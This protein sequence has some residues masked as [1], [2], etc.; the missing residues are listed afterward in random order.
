[1]PIGS[2]DY[3]STT[4][5][6]DPLNPWP[7]YAQICIN[8]TVIGDGDEHVMTVNNVVLPMTLFAPVTPPSNA[9]VQYGT[10]GYVNG[11]QVNLLYAINDVGWFLGI[12]DGDSVFTAYNDT[13]LRKNVPYIY[14][15]GQSGN[16]YQD[17]GVGG[18]NTITIIPV[19]GVLTP[20]EHRRRR[21]LEMV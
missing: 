20:W 18:L 14:V 7:A 4:P 10:G 5:W 8:G 17:T 16:W 2:V 9:Y 1:M 15:A 6:N 21:L 19:T 11:V 13:P 12:D 3:I